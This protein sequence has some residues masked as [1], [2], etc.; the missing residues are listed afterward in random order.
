[1]AAAIVAVGPDSHYARLYDSFQQHCKYGH[2]GRL[3]KVCRKRYSVALHHVDGKSCFLAPFAACTNCSAVNR[4]FTCYVLC[5]CC[6]KSVHSA[7]AATCCQRKVS[8][9]PW[10]NTNTTGSAPTGSQWTSGILVLQ[11]LAATA[12]STLP[13]HLGAACPWQQQCDYTPRYAPACQDLHCGNTS[14]LTPTVS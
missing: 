10:L 13:Q 11:L 14:A 4:C 8:R 12:L 5:A 6:A 3:D 7:L 2:Q 9:Q 1:V